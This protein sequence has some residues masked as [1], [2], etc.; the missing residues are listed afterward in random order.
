MSAIDLQWRRQTLQLRHRWATSQGGINEKQTIVV[1]VTHDGVRGRGEATPSALYGQSLESTEAALQEMRRLVG[2]DPFALH[3]ITE[4]LIDHCDGQRAAIAAVENALHD[5]V[6]RKL[7]IPVWRLLG[8]PEPRVKTTFSIGIADVAEVK[9]KT[10]EALQAGYDRLKVKVGGDH[11]EAT[12]GAIREQFDGP[13][14]LDANQAWSPDA[15]PERIRALAPFRP[16]LIEQPLPVA[17][18]EYFKPLRE[19]GVAPIF[20]DESCERPRD[21]L[22]LSGFVDG[23][24]IKFNKCGGVREALKMVTLARALGLQIMLGCFVC[25]SLAIAPARASATQVDYV[26]LDGALL[27]SDDPFDG[28]AKFEGGLLCA[29]AQPGFGPQH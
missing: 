12:L 7:N 18:W 6:G 10:R 16:T 25:S 9:A 27:L 21:V 26:D 28:L 5:L 23:I 3:E 20:A 29:A 14:L 1:E 24:N 13:L 4:R 17:A 2:D 22:R 15:A 19:L 8:L 11:D